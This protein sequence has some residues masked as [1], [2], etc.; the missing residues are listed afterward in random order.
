M[1]LL[2]CAPRRALVALVFACA[3][4]APQLGA[5][6][7][8][9]AVQVP[10]LVKVL[11]FD[12]LAQAR[13]TD[14]GAIGVLYQGRNRGSVLARDEVI[15]ALHEL[16]LPDGSPVRCVAIDLDGERDLA[17]A[18]TRSGVGALYVTPLRAVEIATVAAASR[19]ASVTTL[20]GSRRYV[21]E[22]LAVGIGLRGDRPRILINLEASK[23]EG[24]EFTAHLLGMAEVLR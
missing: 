4:L 20:T 1:A 8:P 19:K 11:A 13:S 6:D 14:R 18:L 5:Q 2:A 23:L 9:I 24:A 12:R 3:L 15:D 10:L 7:A 22:G 17:A 21:E 16:R